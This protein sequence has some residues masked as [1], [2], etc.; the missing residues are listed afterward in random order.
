MIRKESTFRRAE[1]NPVFFGAEGR[2]N[3]PPGRIE[4]SGICFGPLGAPGGGIMSNRRVLVVDD[5]RGITSVVAAMLTDR[6]YTVD[7]ANDGSSALE[8][9]AQNPYI[10]AVLDYQMPDM[11]GLEVFQRARERLPELLGIFLTAYA[12]ISTVFP[13]IDA[14]IEHVLA[15]PPSREVLI[16]V[17][18]ELIGPMGASSN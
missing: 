9:V 6:G 7:I 1:G 14:G 18:E 16:P 8:L 15:K 4:R 10:L 5:D 13:A 2:E 3:S 11:D 17:V 12:N